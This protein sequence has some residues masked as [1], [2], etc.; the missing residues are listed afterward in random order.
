MTC[1]LE[2]L[3]KDDTLVWKPQEQ[4]QGSAVNHSLRGSDL[5]MTEYKKISEE[6]KIVETC[7]Y[8]YNLKKIIKALEK[9]EPTPPAKLILQSD[10]FIEFNIDERGQIWIMKEE[11]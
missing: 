1:L 6:P 9:G 4:Y 2:I 5:Y 11:K 8:S 3:C 10:I 7:L